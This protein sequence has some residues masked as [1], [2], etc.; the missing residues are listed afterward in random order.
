MF[1]CIIKDLFKF[2]FH[3]GRKKVPYEHKSTNFVPK[4]NKREGQWDPCY[5]KPKGKMEE[6]LSQAEDN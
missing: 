2:R 4:Q 6:I 5:L 1:Y 3:L